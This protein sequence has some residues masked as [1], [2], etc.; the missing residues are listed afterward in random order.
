MHDCKF[1]SNGAK[2]MK[3]LITWLVM[4]LAVVEGKLAVVRAFANANEVQE[5]SQIFAS[6]DTVL[7]CI[8]PP[9]VAID[10]ILVYS[11]RFEDNPE[12]SQAATAVVTSVESGSAAWSSCFQSARSFDARLSQSEDVYDSRGYAARSDW[13]NGPNSV[14]MYVMRSFK[15]GTFGDYHA[16]YFMEFDA[17]PVRAGW[18][19]T[20][21]H[22]A[23]DPQMAIRGSRFRGDT[24]DGFL[25]YLPADVLFHINGNAIYN[26]THPWLTSMIQTLQEELTANTLSAAFD[27]R[28]AQLTL[29]QY[30]DVSLAP[31]KADSIL[32]GNYAQTLLNSS[33]EVPEYIRHASASNIFENIDETQV[34]LG[35]LGTANLSNFMT[36]LRSSHPFR[37]V[38]IAKDTTGVTGISGTETLSSVQG[39]VAVSSFTLSSHWVTAQCEIA[40]RVTT[41]FVMF[42]DALN[43]LA[44]PVYLLVDKQG[45]P[46]LPYIPADGL[47]CT[48]LA[49]CLSELEEAEQLFGVKLNY[50]HDTMETVYNTT[51]FK[52][53]CASYD[54]AV[55]DYASYN[56]CG[57]VN[58]ITADAFIAWLISMSSTESFNYVPRNKQ[59]FGSRA[60][61]MLTAPHAVDTR[62]CSVYTQE[63]R[64]LIG[65]NITTCPQIIEDPVRCQ[66]TTNCTWRPIFGSGRCVTTPTQ[67]SFDFL[68][69]PVHTSTVTTTTTT[70]ASTTM[71]VT[72]TSTASTTTVSTTTVSTTT[73]TSR[74]STVTTT[75]I[76]STSIS[77]TTTQSTI[78]TTTATTTSNTATTITFTV[79][80]ECMTGLPEGFE[81]SACAGLISGQ[82]CSV[83]CVPPLE[84]TSQYFCNQEGVFEGVAPTCLARQCTF[85]EEVST[86]YDSSACDETTT[87][88]FCFVMCPALYEGLE[89]LFFCGPDWLLRG[90]LP[91]CTRTECYVGSLP[92]SDGADFTDCLSNSEGL[93][94]GAGESCQ[95][96]CN[97]GFSGASQ[98]MNCLASGSFQGDAVT[99]TRKQ[100]EI[101]WSDTSILMNCRDGAQSGMAASAEHGDVCV[102]FCAEGF[103]GSSTELSC[104]DGGFQG[105]L[106]TCTRAICTWQAFPLRQNVDNT[107]CNGKQLGESC[108]LSCD[109][110]YTGTGDPTVTCQSNNFYSEPQ[111]SCEPLSC[112]DLSSVDG[113]ASNVV[114]H[115]CANAQYS[116]VCSAYCLDGYQI[117]GSLPD[118]Q[119]A[120]GTTNA[121]FT[122]TDGTAL[123]APTCV[124]QPCTSGF[125]TMR[126]ATHN[127][128]GAVTGE[129]C[130]VTAE[131]GYEAI[132]SDA[133]LQCQSDG[134]ISGQMPVVQPATCAD[135]SFTTGVGSTCQNKVVG[136]ECWAYCLQNYVG[137][138]KRYLCQVAS[139]GLPA[140]T[141][142]SDDIACSYNGTVRR[143][144]DPEDTDD[145]T[146]RRLAAACDSNSVQAFGLNSAEYT[147]SCANL[148]HDEVCISHCSFGW[149]M[150]SESPSVLVCDS[151]TL[152]GSA[153]PSCQALPCNFS[154]PG[155]KV[156]HDCEGKVSLETCTGNCITGYTGNPT[157]IQCEASGNFQGN[158]PTCE[159]LTCAAPELAGNFSHDCVNITLGKSCSVDCAEGYNY[160]VGGLS[161]FRCNSNGTF[162]GALPQCAA[163]ECANT[164]PADPAFDRTTC[165][166]LVYGQS[167][168]VVCNPG[169]AVNVSTLTCNSRGALIGTL[170]LCSPIAC[171]S[172]HLEKTE[173]LDTC[174]TTYYGQNCSIFCARGYE[175][176]SG[177]GLEQLSCTI[178]GSTV[179]LV[180][181][182][183]SC[184]ARPCTDG[185]P[186]AS[187]R[188]SNNCSSI[189][190][191]ER[192]VEQCI[193]GYVGTTPNFVCESD[194]TA[195][196][197]DSSFCRPEICNSGVL[198]SLLS[199]TCE[200][201]SYGENCYAYCPPGYVADQL[202]VRL[203]C[204]GASSTEPAISSLE[205]QEVTL[206]GSLPDCVAA[207]CIYNLPWGDAYLHNCSSVVTG[208]HC[209]VSCA[210]NAGWFGGVEIWT[211]KAT[212]DLSGSYPSCQTTTQTMTRT[213]TTT[214]P[215]PTLVKATGGYLVEW[216]RENATE[217]EPI[218]EQAV[219]E[220]I[221]SLLNVSTPLDLA[222]LTLQVDVVPNVTFVDSNGTNETNMDEVE[223]RRLQNFF[224][225]SAEVE[226]RRLQD[227]ES[228]EGLEEAVRILFNLEF[229]TFDVSIVV[230]ELNSVFEK[231]K[232]HALLIEEAIRNTGLASLSSVRILGFYMVISSDSGDNVTEANLSY[233]VWVGNDP[234]PLE[235]EFPLDILILVIALALVLCLIC[236]F[237][238]YCYRR[239]RT[240]Q[241]D[242]TGTTDSAGAGI[243]PGQ[244][245]KSVSRVVVQEEA[246]VHEIKDSSTGKKDLQRMAEWEG[247]QDELDDLAAL[248]VDFATDSEEEGQ[249]NDMQMI[250]NRSSASGWRRDLEDVGVIFQEEG[251][252][253]TEAAAL[254]REATEMSP[255]SVRL[256]VMD[257]T[258]EP[259]RIHESSDRNDL[260][261]AGII[262]GTEASSWRSQVSETSDRFS[263]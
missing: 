171:D 5:M 160:V 237:G 58:G 193:E 162:D 159:P 172:S 184:T 79:Q 199:H 55:S 195:A 152:A 137:D 221:Y 71:T 15:D 167:C 6:W 54:L 138:A 104:V 205:A 183:P 92:S 83:S 41:E 31:Y 202:A 47:Y 236:T 4:S 153:L 233:R 65:G 117:S 187:D 260:R 91:E 148:A 257:M 9:S 68:R 10:L 226:S 82:S 24:W 127:C 129:Y 67:V 181:D 214:L 235:E 208:E 128:T 241:W 81:T 258:Q 19:Y 234:V 244:V 169:Y 85:A 119:C 177:A 2:A 173:L 140:L 188:A 194:G 98:T 70:T 123:Q 106:P 164:V 27:I 74:T 101:T 30:E 139:D 43:I 196:R 108:Q 217:E 102:A 13:A 210:E 37:K 77:E 182:M 8:N 80:V 170:P 96:A 198:P 20:L 132:P 191:K 33:F 44:S 256:E 168:N 251:L 158:D 134:V 42:T 48:T 118:L 223:N 32:I 16:F 253:E 93:P 99:C 125:P 150:T 143:L 66:S 112:G 64:N 56:D 161:R 46:L 144:E 219:Y 72:R 122:Q 3:W 25:S 231:R 142:F 75:S 34:T 14:F 133:V 38:I 62:T 190:F 242:D 165:S 113:F 186:L 245:E 185:L 179:Q 12:A 220:S 207:R 145:D 29:K 230:D 189:T 155:P 95:V 69:R 50:H 254:E 262:F 115:S 249:S 135:G 131:A 224:E 26:L 163:V 201:V 157:V 261:D 105:G 109:S 86:F 51:Q 218:V 174:D 248:G 225:S 97:Y 238:I 63:E 212:G 124:P 211:C 18:L 126:G 197:D 110:G 116:D 121:G 222:L 259:P 45:R 78:L 22:E 84:G 229:P 156:A 232:N 206:R 107:D 263:I 192:C 53:F 103:V 11:Q 39:D 88:G 243:L 213:T 61:G 239:S 209:L 252:F 255:R 227:F 146:V 57:V 35:V 94:I 178:V 28:M 216:T 21:V 60:W 100:C 17:V 23:Y 73:V 89:S 36:S 250:E 136:A 200:N 151:G 154:W 52:S 130:T 176:S 247:A 59:R 40:Q 149:E 114:G 1:F 49:S 76:S 204:L 87:G 240:K 180:G 120:G 111:L 141:P 90:I 203:R 166:S 215:Q 147:H 175:A 7:P 246:V 228:L